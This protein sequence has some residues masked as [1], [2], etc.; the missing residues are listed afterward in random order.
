MKL[1][2]TG[3]QKGFSL[4]EVLV[5][6]AIGALVIT[7]TLGSLNQG[8]NRTRTSERMLAAK[9][10]AQSKLEAWSA[11]PLSTRPTRGYERVTRE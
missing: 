10:L 5:A 2:A 9:Q 4:V 3:N 8:L 7:A 1:P 6:L 11:S